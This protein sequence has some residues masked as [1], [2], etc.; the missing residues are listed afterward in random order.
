[1]TTMS[2]VA[3]EMSVTTSTPFSMFASMTSSVLLPNASA[4]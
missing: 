4:I 3:T 2:T 1:M